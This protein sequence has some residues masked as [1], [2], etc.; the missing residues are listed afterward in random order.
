MSV[1][2]ETL[3]LEKEYTNWKMPDNRKEKPEQKETSEEAYVRDQI[4]KTY[5]RTE[6]GRAEERI[7]IIATAQNILNKYRIGTKPDKEYLDGI[8][9][10]AA[11][12]ILVPLSRRERPLSGESKASIEE[13]F[14]R[15]KEYVDAEEP[16]LVQNEIRKLYERRGIIKP[17]Q[18]ERVSSSRGSAEA[19][20]ASDNS[21]P[22]DKKGNNIPPDTEKSENM[23]AKVKIGQKWAFK[24]EVGIEGFREV[25]KVDRENNMVVLSATS[26]EQKQFEK[27]KETSGNVGTGSPHKI[28]PLDFLEKY[29]VLIK[30]R[31]EF[32][33]EAA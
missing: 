4:K 27:M 7:K 28:V 8:V 2:A 9:A 11:G 10:I 6:K 16:K 18:S 29:G 14:R 22:I 12:N 25:L 13:G 23:P 24:Q 17:L 1:E 5:S 15:V 30:P 21:Q 26:L 3:S 32:Q 19:Q 33:Q 31:Q 20:V